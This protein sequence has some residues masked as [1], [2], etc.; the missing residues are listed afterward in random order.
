MSQV[1]LID[2]DLRR[3]ILEKLVLKI[4]KEVSDM[5]ITKSNIT[6]E[7]KDFG[8]VEAFLN[9]AGIGTIRCYRDSDFDKKMKKV[10]SSQTL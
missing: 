6:V 7:E 2:Q 4:N 5:V 8:K 9:E 10:L 1:T 3:N